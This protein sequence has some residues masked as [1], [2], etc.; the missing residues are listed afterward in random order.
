M[1][2]FIFQVVP[3]PV[4]AFQAKQIVRIGLGQS[5]LPATIASKSS[6]ATRRPRRQSFSAWKKHLKP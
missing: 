4:Q 3:W 2:R 1:V 6:V 5:H